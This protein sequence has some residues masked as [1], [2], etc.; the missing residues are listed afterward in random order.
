PPKM[1]PGS[2]GPPAGPKPESALGPLPPASIRH[3]QVTASTHTCA[4]EYRRQPALFA[5]KRVQKAE[6]FVHRQISPEVGER[7][8][9]GLGLR[10]AARCRGIRHRRP[11]RSRRS[12][13][14]CRRLRRP[15]WLLLPGRLRGR[16]R[17]RGSRLMRRKLAED[18]VDDLDVELRVAV[19]RVETLRLNVGRVCVE[20]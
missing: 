19:V 20:D 6:R 17:A 13:C 5:A 11:G 12:G 3:I 14:G 10:G 18:A 9:N 4:F 15:A 1:P 2:T 7:A 8:L 16:G